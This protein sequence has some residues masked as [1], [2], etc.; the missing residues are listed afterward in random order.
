[1]RSIEN[2][3]GI[4]FEQALRC[5]SFRI[6]R[7]ARLKPT[8]MFLA[9]ALR[10]GLVGAAAFQH[11][12]SEAT[13]SERSL[14]LNR[15]SDWP[16]LVAEHVQ[17]E[18]APRMGM[19]MQPEVARQIGLWATHPVEICLPLFQEVCPLDVCLE[20]AAEDFAVEHGP[21]IRYGWNIL[22]RKRAE[23]AFR[24]VA[25][26]SVAFSKAFFERRQYDLEE[27]REIA[28]LGE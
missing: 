7:E 4:D 13:R 15:I 14:V 22:L 5:V 12:L 3:T 23:R 16:Q 6:P 11:L 1:M 10:Y 28:L 2:Q 9:L 26:E 27:V 24:E 8:G 19:E 25:D 21:Q 20:V 18:I 17:Y